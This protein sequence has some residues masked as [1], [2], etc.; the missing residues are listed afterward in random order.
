MIKSLEEELAKIRQERDEKIAKIKRT[1]KKEVTLL[2][3]ITAIVLA[4]IVYFGWFY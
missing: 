3:S 1:H 4:S 2:F